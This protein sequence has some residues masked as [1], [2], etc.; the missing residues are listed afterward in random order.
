MTFGEGSRF[1]VPSQFSSTTLQESSLEK[2]RGGIVSLM[3]ATNYLINEKQFVSYGQMLATK[4]TG[5]DLKIFLRPR[6]LRGRLARV[7]VL[8]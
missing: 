1:S 2:K 7:Q 5:A 8:I 6:P 3:K 4:G